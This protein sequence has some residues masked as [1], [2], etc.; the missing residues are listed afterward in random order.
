MCIFNVI[1]ILYINL[2]CRAL[3]ESYLKIFKGLKE[4]LKDREKVSKRSCVML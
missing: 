3:K 2:F 1:F 4:L